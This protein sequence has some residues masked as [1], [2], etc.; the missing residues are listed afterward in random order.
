[1]KV[2]MVFHAPPFPPDIGPSR[3]HYHVLMEVMK[4]HDVHVLSLGTKDDRERLLAHT[5]LPPSRVIFVAG[6]R[7]RPRKALRSAMYL[8]TARS[9]FRRLRLGALQRHLDRLTCPNA[10][11]VVYFSTAM[12]GCY[13]LPGSVPLVGDTHNVEHDN[14]ARAAAAAPEPWRRLHFRAQAVLTRREERAH[15][16]KF[17]I[18]CATSSRDRELLMRAAPRARVEVIPNGI[19]LDKY[20]APIVDGHERGRILFTGLM[21]YYPNQH[22]VLRFVRHV[23]PLVQT[24]VPGARFV[25]AGADPPSSIRALASD[26]IEVTGRVPDVRPFY[27][28]ASAFAVPLSIGGGT[29]VKVLEAMAMG[30]PVVSTSLGCEGLDVVDGRS[31]LLADSDR[32]MADA[33]VRVLQVPALTASLRAHGATVAKSYDWRRIGTLLDAVIRTAA[34]LPGPCRAH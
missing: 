16:Q 33:L 14:L 4:R 6:D 26:Q 5:G 24:R 17:D 23:W 32:A 27:S 13:R 18:V 2:L 29:R 12:L 28:R 3:R 11:D 31:V 21:S 8:M 10:F 19:D 20:A 9:D 30:V 25:V 1:M 15:L 7:T 34:A 22:A